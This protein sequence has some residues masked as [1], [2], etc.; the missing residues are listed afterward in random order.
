MR[1][2]G[3][4]ALCE[5]V[6]VE[7]IYVD[8]LCLIEEAGDGNIRFTLGTRQ[9]STYDGAAMETIVRVRIVAGPTLILFTIR[10]ALAHLGYRCCGAMRSLMH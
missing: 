2:E 7:D 6:V 1:M 9:L 10:A 3:L 4:E 5:P 8:R